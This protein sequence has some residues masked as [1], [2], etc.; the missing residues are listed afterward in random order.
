M[1]DQELARALRAA[2]NVDHSPQFPARVRARVSGEQSSSVWS[3]RSVFAPLAAGAAIVAIIASWPASQHRE[4]APPPVVVSDGEAPRVATSPAPVQAPRVTSGAESS[5]VSAR[6]HRPHRDGALSGRAPQRVSSFPEVV[7]ASEDARGLE[8]LIMRGRERRIP[9]EL[10]TDAGANGAS[11]LT[12]IEIPR[13]T[14]E[15]LQEIARLE[16]DRP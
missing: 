1:N 5:N 6:S 12:R 2:V 15:P 13:L 16:G 10:P 7:I 9:A 14:I 4:T 3:W 8:L 11:T